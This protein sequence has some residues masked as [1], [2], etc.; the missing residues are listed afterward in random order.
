MFFVDIFLALLLA[1][2]ANLFHTQGK[3]QLFSYT[4]LVFT[5]FDI[6]LFY[7]LVLRMIQIYLFIAI[8]SNFVSIFFTTHCNTQNAALGKTVQKMKRFS[9]K[10]TRKLSQ[11]PMS[12]KYLEFVQQIAEY[13]EES[14]TLVLY[15]VFTGR[16]LWNWTTGGILACQLPTNIYLLYRILEFGQLEGF[17]LVVA[18]LIVTLQMGLIFGTMFNLAL[19]M[20]TMYGGVK[21]LPAVQQLLIGGDNVVLCLKI[22]VMDMYERVNS[23]ER[24]GISIGPFD[25]VTFKALFEVGLYKIFRR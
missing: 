25:S 22:K 14:T 7:L 24:P 5:T 16:E 2:F 6:L 21:G 9:E 13:V 1:C 19:L 12:S 20:K 3:F 10:Q 18:L 4:S 11:T 23:D 17:R 15:E 8:L